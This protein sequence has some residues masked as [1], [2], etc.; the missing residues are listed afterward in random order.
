MK[1]MV[2]ECHPAY[3]VL[4][5]EASRVVYAANLHYEVGQTVENPVLL[6]EQEKAAPR[7]SVTMK[8][9]I[10]VA[11]CAMVML[12]GSALYYRGNYTPYA[13]VM[14]CAEANVSMEV[15]RS[16]KVLSVQ[17]LNQD[18]AML[19]S[20][21]ECSGKDTLTVTNELIER[22]VDQGYVQKGDTVGVYYQ[23]E[24]NKDSEEF[25]K[26]VEQS[27][28]FHDLQADVHGELDQAPVPPAA[29]AEPPVAPAP[30]EGK[31]EPPAPP[32]PGK[33]DPAPPAPH[34]PKVDP[35][36]PAEPPVKPETPAKDPAPVTPPEPG[37]ETPP[38]P[39]LPPE[40]P[41]EEKP[42]APA[43]TAPVPPVEAPDQLPVHP[44]QM[45]PV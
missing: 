7:I 26:N 1:Y 13:T 43:D 39:P 31:E 17:P 37:T 22:A 12:G 14:V 25:Q 8:R 10:A 41:A 30:P 3:A 38:E 20:D 15:S 33:N 6:Q 23:K 16:G 45:P 40:A 18:A 19:L 42:A 21:Y 36:A 5:D 4:M 44:V 28:A 34:D 32:Q 11:A 9:C 29:P 24:K 2:M 35:P 27:I